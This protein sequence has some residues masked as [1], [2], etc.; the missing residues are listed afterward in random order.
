MTQICRKLRENK[1]FPC[2]GVQHKINETLETVRD[3]TKKIYPCRVNINVPGE[4]KKRP[5]FDRLLLPEY[6]SNNILQYLMK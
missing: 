4:S 6:I 2:N 1:F 3:S 5:A